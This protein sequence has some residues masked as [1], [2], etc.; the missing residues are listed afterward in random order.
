MARAQGYS[1]RRNS[2][3]PP[4]VAY[5]TMNRRA[6]VTT[7]APS[8]S[9][10]DTVLDLSKDLRPNDWPPPSASFQRPSETWNTVSHGQE[11]RQQR[12]ACL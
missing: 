5:V 11:R 7:I 2:E 6:I 9:N 4:Y 3:R 12:L 1:T 10:R 8:D